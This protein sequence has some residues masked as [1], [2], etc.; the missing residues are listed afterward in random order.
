MLLDE[1][2]E[3]KN[4]ILDFFEKHGATNIL[5]MGSVSRREEHEES[6]VDFVADLKMNGDWPDLQAH[7]DLVKELENYFNRKV[8]IAPHEQIK[9]NYPQAYQNAIRLNQ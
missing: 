1:I 9:E 5:L 4:E 6:D 7:S 8:E 3:R 2:N